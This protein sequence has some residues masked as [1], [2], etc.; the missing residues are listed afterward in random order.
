M[1][2]RYMKKYLLA[3]AIFMLMSVSAETYNFARLDNTH[4][5]SNNQISCIFKDSRGF[6]WI[7]TNY[8]LNRY[9]GYHSRIYKSI[10][11]LPH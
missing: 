8:G 1:I 7:G 9:D 2:T 5:L 11:K 10:K 6:V 4:G 3:V